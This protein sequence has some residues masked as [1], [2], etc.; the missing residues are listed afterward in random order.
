MPNVKK[1]HH[2][3][4]GR[5]LPQRCIVLAVA[6]VL[7]GEADACTLD[8]LLRLPLEQLLE[9]KIGQSSCNPGRPTPATLQ[10]CIAPG[11]RS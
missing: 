5:H 2:V 4:L 8:A 3:H 9:L 11:S 7:A 1:D 6:V 10:S